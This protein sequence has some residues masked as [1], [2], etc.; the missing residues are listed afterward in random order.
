MAV[1]LPSRFFPIAGWCCHLDHNPAIIPKFITRES[2][3]PDSE[4]IMA[5]KILTTEPGFPVT[6]NE[7]SLTAGRCG[8][9]LR[10]VDNIIQREGMMV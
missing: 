1:L 5:R 9:V 10:T 3:L 7:N 6:G 2:Y 4:E 8:L